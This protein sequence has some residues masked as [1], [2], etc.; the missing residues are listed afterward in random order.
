MCI[1]LNLLKGK[2]KRY[3]FKFSILKMPCDS[4]TT[5]VRDDMQSGNVLFG[6]LEFVDYANH[7]TKHL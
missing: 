5:I 7:E 4:D 2:G 1:V 3:M 6:R